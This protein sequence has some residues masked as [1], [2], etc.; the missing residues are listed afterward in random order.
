MLDLPELWLSI[1][2]KAFSIELLPD[3]K[4]SGIQSGAGAAR[5]KKEEYGNLNI[6]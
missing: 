2:I 3:R 5:I 4:R 6:D 1:I